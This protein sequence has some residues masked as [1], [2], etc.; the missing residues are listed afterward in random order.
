MDEPK[1]LPFSADYE[2]PPTEIQ[3][4][5]GFP[6]GPGEKRLGAALAVLGIL[7]ADF[8]IFGGFQLGFALA[9]MGCV[10]CASIYLLRR[11]YRP[12]FY[13]GAL[14]VLSLVIC[15]SFARADDGFVKFMMLLFLLVSAGLGLCLLAK[16]NR[17]R[18]GDAGSL[19]DAPRVLFALGLGRMGNALR[20]LNTARKA[21]GGSGKKRGA[22]LAGL[23][24]SIPIL[25]IVIPLLM[26]SDAAFEGLMDLLP[27]VDWTEPFVAVLFGLPAAL[28]LY[29]A[30]TA[31]HRS[32]RMA[33]PAPMARKLPAVTVNTAL[34]ALCFVYL[35]YLLS[36]LAYLFGGFSGILPEGYTL[37]QYARRGFFEMAWLCAINLTVIA[38]AVGLTRQEGRISPA[39]RWLCLF[40]GLVTLFFVVVACAKMLL[41]IDAY[42]LTRLR[43]LTQVI[44][45]FFGITTCLVCLRLFLPKFAYMKPVVLAGLI[46]GAAVAW[47]DVDSMVAAYNVDSYLAGRLDTVDVSYLQNLGSGAV[48]H[49]ARL[50]QEA[51]DWH[52]A[53]Q[54]E[55]ALSGWYIAKPEDFRDWNYT[56]YAARK[57]LPDTPSGD[58]DIPLPDDI[59]PF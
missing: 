6:T 20:G 54:A 36:Q 42:G 40:L 19:L 55:N 2:A 18:P 57:Y 14:L 34:G 7:L 16:Q 30:A 39:T 27:E 11:G 48:P 24:V 56:D 9:A 50:A 4:D 13:S 46:L 26:R 10:L 49:I 44:L 28:V 53:N 8:V 22:V 15:A 35:V 41:Y 38:L 32:P 33:A 29:T 59:T 43:V 58:T 17:R 47:A 5:P 12:T 3:A 52:L 23:A 21:A 31:L 45:L 37:A 25:A 51:P 1:N